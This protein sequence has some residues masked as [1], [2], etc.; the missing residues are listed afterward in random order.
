MRELLSNNKIVCK[1]MRVM[2][3]M[4]RWEEFMSA[5]EAIQVLVITPL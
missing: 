1:I 2:L 5:F 3:R 4:S